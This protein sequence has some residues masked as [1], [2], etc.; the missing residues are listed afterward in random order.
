MEGLKAARGQQDQEG[1]FEPEAMDL[2]TGERE[3]GGQALM[4]APQRRWDGVD[5]GM[6]AARRCP[7]RRR[8]VGR[9]P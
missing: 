1:K 8:R 5:R 9:E 6:Y 3:E 7:W 4:R 2:E